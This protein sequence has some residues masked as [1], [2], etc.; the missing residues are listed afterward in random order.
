MAQRV[1][2]GK[3]LEEGPDSDDVIDLCR[4]IACPQTA[5]QDAKGDIQRMTP[6]VTPNRGGPTERSPKEGILELRNSSFPDFRQNHRKNE[7]SKR[8]FEKSL[9][10]KCS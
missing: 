2:I 6:A 5:R 10:R 8:V 9:C 7:F 3:V 1:N 4:R